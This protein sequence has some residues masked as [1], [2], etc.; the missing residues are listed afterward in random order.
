[1]DTR[2]NEK[3]GLK[4]TVVA[5]QIPFR[6]VFQ[7]E[8]TEDLVKFKKV[9]FSTL[10]LAIIMAMVWTVAASAETVGYP[11]K[12]GSL[13][14]FPAVDGFVQIDNHGT[15]GVYIK[16]VEMGTDGPGEIGNEFLVKGGYSVTYP[17]DIGAYTTP[18]PALDCFTIKYTADGTELRPYNYMTGSQYY[19]G[20][21]SPA[22]GFAAMTPLSYV[23]GEIPMTGLRG[24]Y[25]AFPKYLHYA[26]PLAVNAKR[27]SM[28]LFVSSQNM[29]QDRQPVLTKALIYYKGFGATR[30]ECVPI[31]N[32]FDLTILEQ[33]VR[34]NGVAST[35]CPGSTKEPLLGVMT[36]YDENDQAHVISPTG[37]GFTTATLLWDAGYQVPEAP[38]RET[39]GIA[40][41]GVKLSQLELAKMRPGYIELTQVK[42]PAK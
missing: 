34:T 24:G 30:D 32:V 27:A 39:S 33:N 38:A 19:E 14:I 11:G 26:W 4:G 41:S 25:D 40:S 10:V 23:R 3:Y 13:L 16:C 42:L 12:Q 17:T 18:A 9:V 8:K 31:H 35:V 20:D 21:L 28:T 22:W 5:M 7:F 29:D 1:M 6:S 15:S 2:S 37:T 36:V